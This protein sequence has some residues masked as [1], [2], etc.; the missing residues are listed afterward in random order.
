MRERTIVD[1]ILF[2]ADDC[3]QKRR[4]GRPLFAVLAVLL[5]GVYFMSSGHRS[6]TVLL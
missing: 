4:H 3:L 6:P 2:I 5:H 1:C